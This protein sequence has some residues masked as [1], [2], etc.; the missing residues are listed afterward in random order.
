MILD[1]VNDA[2]DIIFDLLAVA[3]L[4]LGRAGTRVSEFAEVEPV[5]KAL[6]K[7]FQDAPRCT[8][9]LTLTP[10]PV[11]LAHR[12]DRGFLRLWEMRATGL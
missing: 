12:C 6:L 7:Q 10:R 1:G 8:R 3:Q 2:I 11:R 4:A 9:Y 5:R